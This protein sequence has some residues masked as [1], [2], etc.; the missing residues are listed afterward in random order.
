MCDE[1]HTLT[2]YSQGCEIKKKGLGRLVENAYRTL[3]N[4]YILNDIKEE[5]VYMGKIDES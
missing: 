1:E 3:N 4:V 2:F 5:K